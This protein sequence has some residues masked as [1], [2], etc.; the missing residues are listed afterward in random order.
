MSRRGLRRAALIVAAGVA[1]AGPGMAAETDLANLVEPYLKARGGEALGVVTARAYV[2][3]TRVG[4][5]PT[6]QPPVSMVLLPY[7]A[8]FEAE[9]DA[10]KAGLR[11]SVDT[12]T[13]AV[14]RIESARV[15]YERALVTVGAGELVRSE[16]T[17]AQGLVELTGLPA[18]D[19]LLLAW[20]EGAH[21]SKHYKIRDQDA[22]RYPDLPTT[23][24]YSM[25]TYWRARV[26]VRRGE[27]AEVSMSDRSVWM[28]APRQEGGSSKPPRPPS[29]TPKR[30]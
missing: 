5:A 22:K 16:A 21:L 10:V 14:G 9:L 26:T 12:F 19:W 20:R 1:V 4:A 25:V 30:R 8:E 15:E 13:Q 27:T 3:P 7:S 29:S 23:V 17:D 2:E 24:T 18:G 28:T 11:N 6:P